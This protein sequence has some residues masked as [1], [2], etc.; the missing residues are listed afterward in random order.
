MQDGSASD[1]YLPL[2]NFIYR[3]CSRRHRR[4]YPLETKESPKRN[5]KFK[6]EILQSPLAWLTS[7]V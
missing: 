3:F 7:V 2:H 5:F 4:E 1:R 6:T